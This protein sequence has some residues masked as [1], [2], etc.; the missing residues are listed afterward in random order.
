M[1]NDD[2]KYK[3]LIAEKIHRKQDKIAKLH[4]KQLTLKILLNSYYGAL[5]S[6]Y[7]RY[8]DIRLAKS[9]TL[10]G[11]LA[12]KW[13]SYKL[14]KFLLERFNQKNKFIIGDTDSVRGDSIIY[15]NNKRIR[16]DDYYNSVPNS[17]LIMND[18]LNEQYVKKVN[19]DTSISINENKEIEV[20][21]ISYIMKHK[22]K[23]RMFKLKYKGK[24][25]IL[26]ED[27]GMIVLRNN[28]MFTVKP[29]EI[30]NGDKL[31]YLK[32]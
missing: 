16:I 1:I 18:E 9:I 24:E 19:N 23:K 14:E 11:Q 5:A 22:I 20:N 32:K 4:N 27:H 29:S 30:I 8:F 7:F 6:P 2:I 26:T 10:S 13:V 15:V 28:K 17:Q 25:L 31:I 21:S 3:Q 12:I